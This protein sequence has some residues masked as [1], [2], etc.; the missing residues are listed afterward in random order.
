MSDSDSRCQSGDSIW[1]QIE[2]GLVVAHVVPYPVATGYRCAT[3]DDPV[4]LP[5]STA[6][7]QVLHRAC[8]TSHAISDCTLR[9]HLRTIPATDGITLVIT[10]LFV[11]GATAF[12]QNKTTESSQTIVP[13]ESNSTNPGDSDTDPTGYGVTSWD[14]NSGDK[15]PD[16]LRL[17][18]CS[19]I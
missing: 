16:L 13:N 12:S 14:G 17:T 10:W 18:R 1:D 5:C 4:H 9:K 15:S 8:W 6:N 19:A 11:N 3:Y 2:P 7:G